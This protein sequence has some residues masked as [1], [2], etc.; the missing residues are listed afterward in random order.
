MHRQKHAQLVI[1]TLHY[2]SKVHKDTIHN[3]QLSAS[4]LLYNQKYARTAHE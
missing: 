2:E 1:Y 3:Y 4:V